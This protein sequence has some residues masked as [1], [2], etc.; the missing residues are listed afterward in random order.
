TCVP[1]NGRI[2]AGGRVYVCRTSPTLTGSR[3]SYHAT[4]MPNTR[5]RFAST[6]RLNVLSRALLAHT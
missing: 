5:V 1:L 2:G 4:P 6:T 3:F